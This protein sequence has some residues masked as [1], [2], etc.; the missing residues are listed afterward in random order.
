[1]AKLRAILT[2]LFRRLL[3]P[4]SIVIGVT[5]LP[6]AGVLSFLLSNRGNEWIREH[7]ESYLSEKLHTK[8]TIGHISLRTLNSLGISDFSVLD[9]QGN[10]LI[11]FQSLSLKP[12][13]RYFLKSDQSFLQEVFINNLVSKIY[14]QPGSQDFNYQ[15]VLDAFASPKKETAANSTDLAWV[16]PGQL[17]LNNSTVTYNDANKGDSASVALTRL[18][19]RIDIIDEIIPSKW[20]FKNILLD[21]AEVVITSGKSTYPT[22]KNTSN[23]TAS[24][25]NDIKIDNLLAVNTLFRLIDTENGQ[26]IQ[27][28]SGC[29]QFCK[30][31][32]NLDQHRLHANR[33]EV[34]NHFTAIKSNPKKKQPNSISESA[35]PHISIDTLLLG[36]TRFLVDLG[37]S[38][39]GTKKEFDPYHNDYQDINIAATSIDYQPSGMNGKLHKLAFHENK[40]F[41]LHAMSGEFSIKDSLLKVNNLK[42]RTNF[43]LLEGNIS[44][45]YKSLQEAISNPENTRFGLTAKAQKLNLQEISYFLPLLLRYTSIYP[46]YRQNISLK[47]QASGSTQN[48]K[49]KSFDIT[50]Q[51]NRLIGS[52]EISI[53]KNTD[54]QVILAIKSAQTGRVGIL[55]VVSPA[56][57]SPI[58]DRIP[59]KIAVN[60]TMQIS[61]TT[62]SGKINLN[63]DAGYLFLN[64]KISNFSNLKHTKY[65]LL[66]NSRNFKI[67][68]ILKDTLYGPVTVRGRI[69]GA[70]IA[71]VDNSN[72]AA[73][74]F[75][76]KIILAKKSIQSVVFQTALSKGT[77]RSYLAS[78]QPDLNFELSPTLH[79]NRKDSLLSVAGSILNMDLR[80]LGL[81][82]DSL[83][84]SGWVDAYIT[85]FSKDSLIAKI[86]TSS[87]RLVRNDR[88]YALDSLSLEA[89]YGNSRQNIKIRSTLADL[90]LSGRFAINR[91]PDFVQGLFQSIIKN[92]ALP[93]P[94]G[95][96]F[97]NLSGDVHVTSA[98]LSLIPPI[99][100]LAPF[101]FKSSY[102][103]PDGTFGFQTKIDSLTV[104]GIEIDSLLVQ[105]SLLRDSINALPKTTYLVGLKNIRSEST[106]LPALELAGQA[107]DGVHEAQLF[108]RVNSSENLFLLPVRYDTGLEKPYLSFSGPLHFKKQLW[109]VDKNNALYITTPGL[110]G[111][112][113]KIQNGLKSITFSAGTTDSTGLPYQLQLANIDLSPL[114][115]LLKADS[116]FISGLASGSISVNQLEPLALTALVTID[117][118]ELKDTPMG[119]L[120]A[121]IRNESNG[122][123]QLQVN[124][125][126]RSHVPLSATGSYNP[127]KRSGIVAIKANSFSF[128]PF[129]KLVGGELDSLQG[130]VGGLIT[131]KI[132][133][134]STSVNGRLN[135]DSSAF[136]VPETGTHI[137]VIEGGLA[138]RGNKMDLDNLVLSDGS[139]GRGKVTGS[140]DFT[141]TKNITYKAKLDAKNFKTISEIQKREQIIYGNGKTDVNLDLSGNLQQFRLTGGAE[142]KDS[143]EVFYRNKMISKPS[144]GE[145]LLEFAS[146]KNLAEVDNTYQT[147]RI[148]QLINTSISVSPS[149]ALTLI[150]DEYKGEK[151]VIRGKSNL[152]YSQHA[153]GEML[154]NGKFEV[155]SG[156]YIL[157]VGNNIKREFAL[158][159]GGTIQWLGNVY[160]PICDLTAVYKVTAS[161]A[162][163]MQGTSTSY[164]VGKRK[165]DFLV[166]LK[167]KGSLSKPEISFELGMNEKDQ[168]AYDGTVYS[169]IKEINN[170]PSDVTKQVMSLLVLNSFM[171]DSPFGS[172]TQF[173]NTG[174][175]A[176][177]YNTI[178]NMLTQELNTLLAGMV[179]TVDITLGVD[180]SESVDGGRSSTRSDIRL[181][182]GKSLFDHRLNLYVGNN[183]GIETVSGRNSGFSGLANDVSVEY[184]LTPDGKYRIKGYHVRDNE[185][186]LHGEHMETGVKFTIVWEFDWRDLKTT[187]TS[188][189]KITP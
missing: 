87:A 14:R 104:N 78:S 13:W 15:F 33:I 132:D 169:K 64:G 86:K 38:K 2:S 116:S 94:D 154:L 34:N 131:V 16:V 55:D 108:S 79:F 6:T 74:G 5:I 186:T 134:S 149:T 177:A 157:I 176:G 156:T 161:A 58:L 32:L 82:N 54:S 62:I 23:D 46:L 173:S 143:S 138:F 37:D 63:S 59:K 141:N 40:Q 19:A 139:T 20:I 117:D 9:S 53:P 166:K 170:S 47:V 148:N 88:S 57:L 158:E 129:G 133:S 105:V 189:K 90:N 56:V 181:G 120:T 115:G 100:R 127:V 118:L 164:E 44:W 146:K 71:D 126:D 39:K 68:E 27:S 136:I 147:K 114:S 51:H 7:L 28:T 75:L 111:S 103:Y 124:L 99:S 130:T 48:I 167:L 142:L 178:G 83:S 93:N 122:Q 91:F 185:L 102:S 155:T 182:L 172:L 168:D 101:S 76:D 11:S 179:K 140:V 50:T 43:N 4:A 113:L 153:G 24:W 98:N 35:I 45:K 159:N 29:V 73:A 106:S 30:V 125:K 180:W 110:G 109:D 162:T 119:K 152:S 184:L 144:F 21:K 31:A 107:T 69:R 121:E 163:L 112:Q 187:K 22:T 42:L 77:L 60:G 10:T 61:A 92:T 174:L 123:Y 36:D 165:F 151:V 183:F 81:L 97:F 96:N 145:G 150:L 49:L 137:R 160:Q 84:V 128:T 175:E 171:G 1:M 72:F 67:G 12:H 3:L 80:K 17:E 52:G 65:D 70:G 89:D 188:K 85:H 18:Q 41:R 66:F 135:I 25:K 26:T 95:I 8:V